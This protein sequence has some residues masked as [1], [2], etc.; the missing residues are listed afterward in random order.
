MASQEAN[1][2]CDAVVSKKVKK[3]KN[4]TKQSKKN[5]AQLK[6]GEECHTDEKRWKF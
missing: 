3:Y 6:K 1:G 5:Q 4:E 2:K